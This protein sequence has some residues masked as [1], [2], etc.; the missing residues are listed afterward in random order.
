MKEL[1]KFIYS[2]D[3]LS[4]Q[5]CFTETSIYFLLEFKNKLDILFEII[6]DDEDGLY[7]ITTVRKGGGI[8]LHD[9]GEINYVIKRINDTLIRE[10][11]INKTPT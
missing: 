9:Y 10:P 2:L 8:L 1:L 4:K 7:A 6:I 5:V 3:L 11:S